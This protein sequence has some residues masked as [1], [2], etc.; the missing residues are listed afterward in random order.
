MG[1]DV[2]G[3]CKAGASAEAV[4]VEGVAGVVADV[5]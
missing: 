1:L 3:R 5:E 2:A 4:E